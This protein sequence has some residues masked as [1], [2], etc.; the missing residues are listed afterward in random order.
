MEK[1][2]QKMCDELYDWYKRSNAKIGTR[3][4]LLA[5]L[6]LMETKKQTLF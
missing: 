6:A 1:D 2:E 5:M 4:T 3:K